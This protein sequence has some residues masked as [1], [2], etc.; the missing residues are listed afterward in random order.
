MKNIHT[1]NYSTRI[2]TGFALQPYLMAEEGLNCALKNGYDYWYVDGSIYS[3]FPEHWN[4]R[5][6]ENLVIQ[7]TTHNIY[8]IFHGN[9][10]IPLASDVDLLRLAAIEYAKKEIDLSSKLKSPLIIHGSV[11][12]EP[13]TVKE[14]KKTALNNLI[15]SLNILKPYADEKGVTLWLENLSNYNSYRPFHYIATKAEE[16]DAILS[17][18]EIKI[19]FD[20]GHANVN[21]EIPVET[22]FKQ[23]SSQI[24]GV[25]LS[26]ND[27]KLDQH[28]K[29]SDGTIN[30]TNVL[31]TMRDLQWRGI[32][33]FETRNITPK[34]AINSFILMEK[35]LTALANNQ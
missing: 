26:N 22:F 15:K 25:S 19:F 29:L 17:R 4:E 28:L 32:I 1:K 16:F 6:I 13:R 12:V 20:F 10:K 33:G 21:P 5:R 2:A 3:E 9:F 11:I 18:I 7:C 14:A 8:P 35:N 24:A 31:Q 27:G 23:F 30:Y 34:A